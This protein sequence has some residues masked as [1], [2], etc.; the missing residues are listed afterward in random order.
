LDCGEPS[1]VVTTGPCRISAKLQS[2]GTYAVDSEKC[3]ACG[4]CFKMGC[5]AIERAEAVADGKR[6]KPAISPVQCSGC[7]LC[8]QVC[9]FGAISKIR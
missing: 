1:V 8:A 5:P 2:A 9:K 3:K 7:D 4:I 6:F